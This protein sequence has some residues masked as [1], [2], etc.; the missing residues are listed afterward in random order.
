MHTLILILVVLSVGICFGFMLGLSR[1]VR[2]AVA[3]LQGTRPATI[4]KLVIGLGCAALLGAVGTGVHTWH[5][6]RTAHRTIGTVIEM[7]EH[8]DKDSGSISYAPTF[9]F[10]DASGTVRTVTSRFFSSPPEFRVGD[11]VVVLYRAD[12]PQSAR[13]A[14]YWQLWGAPTLLGMIGGLELLI[15]LAMLLWP[16]ITGRFRR[17]SPDAQAA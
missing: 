9:R 7:Q 16:K 10:Q 14:S 17:Q 4:A 8:T 12:S 6:T 11:R 1:V 13:I 15:G 3:R 2:E 5:F